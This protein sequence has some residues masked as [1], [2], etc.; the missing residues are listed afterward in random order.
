MIAPVAQ[1]PARVCNGSWFTFGNAPGSTA[2]VQAASCRPAFRQRL[3][4]QVRPKPVSL[5]LD[6]MVPVT[7][8]QS[9]PPYCAKERPHGGGG[10][11]HNYSPIR[12]CLRCQSNHRTSGSLCVQPAT[13]HVPPRRFLRRGRG[14]SWDRNRCSGKFDQVC[15]RPIQRRLR[16]QYE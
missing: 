1:Q 11:V 12:T 14:G 9:E 15:G 6:R 4:A 8:V 7:R 13:R 3:T 16:A 10:L 2:G 5:C